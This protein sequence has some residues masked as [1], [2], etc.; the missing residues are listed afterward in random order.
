MLISGSWFRRPRQCR[1]GLGDELAQDLGYGKNFL[2]TA[3]DRSAPSSYPTAW[4]FG[5][6]SV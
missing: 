3:R 4:P 1:F 2:D 5:S 6:F